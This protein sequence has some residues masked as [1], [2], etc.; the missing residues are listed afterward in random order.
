MFLYP[1]TVLPCFHLAYCTRGRPGSLYGWCNTIVH[2][3]ATYLAQAWGYEKSC[4]WLCARQHLPNGKP[5]KVSRVKQTAMFTVMEIKWK[6][7]LQLATNKALYYGKHTSK[8]DL[9]DIRHHTLSS[10]SG[11]S[12]WLGVFIMPQLS[13][14]ARSILRSQLFT[15]CAYCKRSLKWEETKFL[16]KRF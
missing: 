6:T 7:Q 15:G 3:F 9:Y 5:K 2:S 1:Q 11:K 4:P 12:T 8:R 10:A 13:V 16:K 14:P